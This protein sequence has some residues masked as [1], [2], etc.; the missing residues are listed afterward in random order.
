MRA[1]P[2][3]DR[4]NLR[5]LDPGEQQQQSEDRFDIDR[6]EEERI[7]VEVHRAA[8]DQDAYCQVLLG[9]PIRLAILQR[10]KK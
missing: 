10:T 7:D 8:A 3:G 6:D 2:P 1:A 4:A 5:V 9:G